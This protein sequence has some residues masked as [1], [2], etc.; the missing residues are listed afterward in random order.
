MLGVI[1]L[2]ICTSIV[3]AETAV[4][5][6]VAVEDKG[7]ILFAL[8]VAVFVITLPAGAVTLHTR[9]MLTVSPDSIVPIATVIVF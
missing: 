8:T 3:G 9:V 2:V 1:V 4:T 7:V 5:V 6:T